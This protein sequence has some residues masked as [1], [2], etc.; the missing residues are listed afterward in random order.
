MSQLFTLRITD[1]ISTVDFLSDTTRVLDAGFDIGMPSVKRE[2][3]APR[4]GFYMPM[5]EDYQFR[6]ARLRF[7]AYGNT[8]NDV[9][10]TF[11]K[12][13]R[14]IRQGARRVKI[15]T[16]RRA[17]LVYTWEGSDNITYF[18]IYGG[19][20]ILP[21][22][23]LS[24]EKI[25]KKVGSKYMVEAELVLTIS[26]LG[27]GISVNSIEMPEIPLWNTS[28]WYH[29]RFPH[30]DAPR[31][32]GIYIAQPGSM[33]RPSNWIQIR[34]EDVPGDMPLITKLVLT[35]CGSQST[36]DWTYIG[37]QVASQEDWFPPRVSLVWDDTGPWAWWHTEGW[38]QVTQSGA[39]GGYYHKKEITTDNYL[40]DIDNPE[41]IF[42]FGFKFEGGQQILFLPFWHGYNGNDMA[43]Y[44]PVF[45]SIGF[46]YMDPYNRH[47]WRSAWSARTIDMYRNVTPLAP[48]PVPMQ[49]E[50]VNYGEA[51]IYSQFALWMTKKEALPAG[52]YIDLDY[53]SMLPITHGLRMWHYRAYEG[54]SDSHQGYWIDDDWLGTTLWKRYYAPSEGLY[55]DVRN[56]L[57]GFMKPIKLEPGRLQ[58]LY[59]TH[60]GADAGNPDWVYR[61]QLFAV[62]TYMMLAM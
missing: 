11:N 30:R 9:I 23:I 13:E 44:D 45:Y 58:R 5:V 10:A 56:A 49:Q 16:E 7:F 40:T 22:N 8:R 2:Y 26:A 24:V 34:P 41:W 60:I 54:S 51:E 3:Y 6:E 17:E 48:L 39:Y 28:V 61:V 59:F 31:L 42:N 53:I 35:P 21:Q 18:E 57:D 20:L 46:S 25:H 12:I 52:K 19:E 14:I 32:G 4:P 43:G 36:K 55:G 38:T 62:P 37:L 15:V 1:N 50:L 47:N 33:V 27:Y 29:P